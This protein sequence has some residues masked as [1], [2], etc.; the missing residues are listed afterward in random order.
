MNKINS[1]QTGKG[2]MTPLQ[3]F[4]SLVLVS[5][6]VLIILGTYLI[7]L[8]NYAVGFVLLAVGVGILVVFWIYILDDVVF[9]RHVT[10]LKYLLRVRR[11]QAQIHTLTLPLKELQKHI[12]LKRVHENGLIEYLGGSWGIVCRYDPPPVSKASQT[13]H[14][15][16]MEK[17]ANSIP[18]GVTVSFHF[19]TQI[20]HT[21][22]LADTV[23]SSMNLEGKTQ[24]QK[25]H[26]HG[27][28]TY[29]TADDTPKAEPYYLLAINLGKFG[30]K[31]Q[32][33]TAYQFTV[34]GIMK[35]MATRRI[36]VTQLIGEGEIARELH[37]F[38]IMERT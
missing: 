20:N 12:P 5:I 18:T 34:P 26:L 11:G 27:L 31:K 10:Y 1:K 29:A 28:Y 23:L 25:E 30:S 15:A 6:G 2:L 16:Q 13:S 8:P 7:G 35:S 32:A 22:P 38:A 33:R 19:Y 37:D 24:A 36:Y 17:I 9:Y 4:V 21:N 14:H 3:T